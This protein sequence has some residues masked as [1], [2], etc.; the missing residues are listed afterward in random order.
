MEKISFSYAGRILF[1]LGAGTILGTFF[2]AFFQDWLW[3]LF[4][5]LPKRL[6]SSRAIMRE[7]RR[8]LIYLCLWRCAEFLLPGFLAEGKLKERVWELWLFVFA[9]LAGIWISLFT[10]R[11]RVLGMIHFGKTVFPQWLFYGLGAYRMAGSGE[12]GKI[13]KL[14]GILFVFAGLFT[15]ILFD[16]P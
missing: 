3:N 1:F 16:F 7:D 12:G 8:Y 13:R 2:A 9:F 15:E 5:E 14:S 4:S 6:D 11:Y 10:L